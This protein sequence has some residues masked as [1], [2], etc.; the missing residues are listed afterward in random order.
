[1]ITG[2]TKLPESRL[3]VAGNVTVLNKPFG[4]AEFMQRVKRLA[5]NLLPHDI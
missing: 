1:M 2:R 3:R 5:P 4:V